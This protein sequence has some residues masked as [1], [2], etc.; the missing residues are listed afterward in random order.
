LDGHL[1]G[2]GVV[3]AGPFGDQRP[4]RSVGGEDAVVTV[5][6]DT[7]WREEVGEAVKEL[8][9]GETEGGTAGQVGPREQVENL[10]GTAVDEMKAVESEGGPGTIPDQ[11]FEAG[12]VGGLDADTPIQTES[13]P[14][15][16]GQHV[17][18]LVGLQEAVA[19]EVAQ[20]PFSDSMLEAL[21]EFGCESRGFVEAEAGVRVGRARIRVILDPLKE[22]VHDAQMEMEVG[23]EAG[24]EAMEEAHSAEGGADWSG[25]T[26]LPEGGVEGT[27]QDVEDGA[28]GPGPVVE[29]GSQAF[30]HGEDELADGY[31]GKDVVYQV[32]RGLGHALGVAGRTY[33][34][35]L[36]GEGHQ[37]VVAAACAS[38]PSEPVGQDAAL[39]VAPELL[40]HVIRHAFAHGIGLVGQGEVGL[41]VFPDDA[42][43]GS[44]LGAAPPVRLG[45]GA[46]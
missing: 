14:V 22:P 20:H 36:A 39:E 7:G 10:V 23:I 18:G 38:G 32:G 31:V 5:T 34:A 4:Q 25:G 24:S 9:S 29:E 3:L 19:T 16:P 27:E 17:L 2:E 15:I 44:G 41:Q 12:A 8:E 26:G 42:V 21:E 6:V 13:T 46:G 37:E 40:F 11:P 43:Q 30:G 35:A 33:P 45:M 1:I 28:G